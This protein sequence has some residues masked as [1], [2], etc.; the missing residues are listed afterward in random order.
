MS[1]YRPARGPAARPPHSR[2]FTLI[3][4]LVVIAIIA[5]LIGLLLPAV[6][7]VRE[8]A[9]RAKCQNNLKQIGLGLHN[10][11][12][13]TQKFPAGHDPSVSAGNWRVDIFPYMELGNV[14]DQLP[15]LGTANGRMKKNVYAAAPLGNL[16]LPIWKCPSSALTETTPQGWVTWW[17]QY[18]HMVPGYQGIMG[19]Y[20]DPGGSTTR[21]SASNYGGW[22]TNNGM[23]LWA[24]QTSI[25]ACTDGTSNTIVVAEQS[26]KV[27]DCTYVQGDARNGYYSPWGGVTNTS[28]RGVA[29]CGAAGCGDLWGLGLTANAYQINST[30]CGAGANTSYVGNT[31]L[32]SFHTGGIN[33]LLGD[34]SVRFVPDSVDFTMFQRMCARDDGQVITLQ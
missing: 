18:N 3:E 7:K 25:A 32:N 16:V 11:E 27:R 12:S 5:I 10:F 26:G 14:Y 15:N 19:A 22:W 31:I 21:H 17:T 24:E 9:A 28:A 13:A 20:P 1:D 30:T 33:V 29:S 34:G 2:G 4:L 6:Q 8:A 23:L